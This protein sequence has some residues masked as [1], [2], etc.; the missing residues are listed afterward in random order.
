MK[1]AC[2]QTDRYG[3]VQETL[4]VHVNSL[5]GMILCRAFAAERGEVTGRKRKRHN[6]EGFLICTL[7]GILSE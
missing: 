6:E 3:G 2:R 7:H 1:E 5:S 4:F